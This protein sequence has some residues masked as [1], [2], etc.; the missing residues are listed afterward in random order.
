MEGPAPGGTLPGTMRPESCERGL[1]APV[2]SLGRR[3]RDDDGQSV[4]EGAIVLPA[5]VFLVLTIMQLTMVQHARIM[6]AYAA[7]CAAR[8]GIVFNGDKAAME[9]AATLA[10]LPT[11]GRTDKL[12]TL[13]TTALKTFT[14][15]KA[16]RAVFGL[17][18]ARVRTLSPT[19]G[20]FGTLGK[21]LGGKEIDFDDVRSSAAQA[22]ILQVQV[23]YFYRMP[24]PF[25]NQI[26][27]NI[28]FAQRLNMLQYW[29]GVNMV[30]PEL[31]VGG[32][33]V[34]VNAQVVTRFRYPSS[35]DPDAWKLIAA[36]MVGPGAGGGYYFPLK[37]TYS[38][39]MQSNL[40][41]KNVGQ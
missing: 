20:V 37:A 12:D 10:L 22:N 36:A 23:E 34:G 16:K 33:P 30:A 19:S 14:L 4:V 1:P 32:M 5:M 3:L 41:L 2:P 28:F 15:E 26:L 35:G 25:A 21:H 38:M 31:S 17:P 9:Q 18:I 13:T 39:R 24:I 8:A 27:Q 7:Y 11:I 6:T 29:G 40:Y